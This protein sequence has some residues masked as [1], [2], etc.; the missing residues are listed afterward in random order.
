LN[1]F[2]LQPCAD[3]AAILLAHRIAERISGTVQLCALLTPL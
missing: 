3:A 1:F 2:G